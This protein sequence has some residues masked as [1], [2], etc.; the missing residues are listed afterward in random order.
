MG[1]EYFWKPVFVYESV[2]KILLLRRRRLVAM[3]H[4]ANSEDP[5]RDQQNAMTR[6]S[7]QGDKRID[8]DFMIVPL[9]NISKA[10]WSSRTHI[11]SGVIRTIV[12]LLPR[13]GIYHL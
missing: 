2:V 12:F 9:R 11:I 4:P 3:A 1:I 5:M 8:V 13:A 6:L 7:N 10:V